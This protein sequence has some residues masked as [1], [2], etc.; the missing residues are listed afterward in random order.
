MT[1]PSLLLRHR[2][3]Q[4]QHRPR[5]APAGEGEIVVNGRSLEE[6][7]GNAVDEADILMPFRV[8]STEGRFNAMIKVEGGGS[9]A[10]PAPSA[11]ASPA[12]CSSPTPRRSGCRSARPAS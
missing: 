9:P 5:P 10:R 3:P 11:T 2:P 1:T 8:T 6:H 12:P 7:F 4:D